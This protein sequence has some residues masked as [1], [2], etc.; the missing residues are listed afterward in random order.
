MEDA[1]F[2]KFIADNWPI[3]THI[4]GGNES[5]P[6]LRARPKLVGDV[7]TLPY[8]YIAGQGKYS[9]IPD[10]FYLKFHNQGEY[11][12]SIIIECCQ[13]VQN[14]QQKR[15][16]YAPSMIATLAHIPAQWMKQ[17]A[18]S[19]VS[20]FNLM[21]LDVSQIEDFPCPVRASNI[22]YV[23]PDG[24]YD[25]L[26]ESCVP[27]HFE[28]F[29]SDANFRSPSRNDVKEFLRRLDLWSRFFA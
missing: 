19:G 15:G 26:R 17:S 4:F 29:M 27:H 1:V 11:C 24:L 20:R 8:L 14:F 12:D 21:G 2:K 13:T 28:Y 16:K 23:L 18:G 5:S 10:G 22:L 9:M 7:G 6:W 25:E 3:Y